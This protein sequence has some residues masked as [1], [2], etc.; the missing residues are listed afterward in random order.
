ILQYANR[1]I[2]YAKQVTGR[3]LAPE[4]EALLAKAPSN[5]YENGLVSYEKNVK[6]AAVDLRRVGMH[7]AVATV[8]AEEPEQL[9]LFNYV[10]ESEV[11]KRMVA[12]EQTLVMGRVTIQSR[13]SLSRKQFSFSAL[14]LGQQNIIG[15]LSTKL[16]AEN[17]KIMAEK[18]EEAYRTP[19]LG[20]VIGIMQDYF[21][22]EKYSIW[23]LFRDE[24][25][26]ILQQIT[27]Q[28]LQQT[29]LDFRQIYERNYQ[30]MTGMLNS[31]IPLPIA[32]KSAIQ[33]VL[34]IDLR[35][36]FMS[37]DLNL[38]QL[39]HLVD[40]FKKWDVLLTDV[41]QLNL[42]ASRRL[43][44]EMEKL[45]AGELD[46]QRL[47]RINLALELQDELGLFLNLWRSQNVFYALLQEQAGQPWA[48]P[49]WQAAVERLGEL[50]HVRVG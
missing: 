48:D 43:H 30:L 21:G 50:L 35:R 13:V 29:E 44:L 5:V 22:S 45:A 47:Q 1:A 34:N 16:S 25:R 9:A 18:A 46:L 31:D 23:H 14:H 38:R 49:E 8:F 27:D 11:L 32:Y 33:Y 42:V 37:P 40:E 39:R 17:F 15:N 6:P 19:D 2:H 20:K 7:F 28:S 4:F 24:K 10:A 36:A 41:S 26:K 3:N 12:G